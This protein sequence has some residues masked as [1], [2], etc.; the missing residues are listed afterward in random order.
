MLNQLKILNEELER[1]V[2]EKNGCILSLQTEYENVSIKYLNNIN[3]Y[4]N[5]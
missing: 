1:S 5:V 4:R 2:N 3:F